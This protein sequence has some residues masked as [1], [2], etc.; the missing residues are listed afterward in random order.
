MTT[1][2]PGAAVRDLVPVASYDNYFDAQKAV[3]RLSDAG[4]P[5]ERTAIIGVGLQMVENVLGRLN[6]GRAAATGAA[7]GAWFGLLVGVFLSIFTDSLV[8]SVA[9][10]L[11]AVLWGAIACAIFG[12]IAY[13]F[14]GGNRDFVSASRLVAERYDVRV[15]A[16]YADR[17]R[18]LLG[19]TGQTSTPADPTRNAAVQTTIPA[20]PT[21]SA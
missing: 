16:A 2:A 4:F 15:D 13:A 5:V 20:D 18:E 17:A 21:R 8:S 11:W 14:T 3:D 12:A 19:L 1:P 10:I 6:Y 7:T 9:I